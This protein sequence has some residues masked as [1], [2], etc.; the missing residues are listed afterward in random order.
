MTNVA[1]GYSAT[2]V[3]LTLD[4]EAAAPL[5]QMALTS[6]TFRPADLGGGLATFNAPAP[7]PNGAV[8]LSIFDG[9]DPNGT[10]RLWVMEAAPT[11]DSG[12]GGWSL[13]ITA[14]ADVQVQQQVKET[15]H[16]KQGKRR[17]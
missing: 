6:G 9:A 5:S 14:E 16:M 3:D 1:N 11:D 12:I 2:D 15:K 7:A 8:A 4:D 13:Q 10:W 17:H